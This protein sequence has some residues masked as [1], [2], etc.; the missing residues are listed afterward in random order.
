MTAKEKLR[1]VVEELSEREASDALGYFASRHVGELAN[2][3]EDSS[4]RRSL[5]F[6]AMGASNSGRRAAEAEEMLG[7]GFG[8]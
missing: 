2:R 5:S 8:R 4:G 6:V 3:G 1:A 7:E